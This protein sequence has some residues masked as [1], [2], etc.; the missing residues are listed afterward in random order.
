MLYCAARDGEFLRMSG[1]T[2]TMEERKEPWT[3]TKRSNS[4]FAIFSFGL[5]PFVINGSLFA[6][7]L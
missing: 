2:T 5:T 7:G 6:L 1:S 3:V 4:G